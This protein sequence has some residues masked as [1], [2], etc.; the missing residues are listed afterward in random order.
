[1]K[2]K[3]F[4]LLLLSFFIVSDLLAQN[5]TGTDCL[6]VWRRVTAFS[7][8]KTEQGGIVKLVI[9]TPPNAQRSGFNVYGPSIHSCGSNLGNTFELELYFD[10]L[11]LES[12]I[13]GGIVTYDVP[14]DKWVDIWGRPVAEGTGGIRCHYHIE[15]VIIKDNEGM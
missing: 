8:R 4:I 13:T 10:E 2:T 3:S 6:G 11:Y 14:V 12:R 15:V 9:D 1:M 5:P 7:S